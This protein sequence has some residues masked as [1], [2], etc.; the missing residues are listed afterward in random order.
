VNLTCA[1]DGKKT[2]GL[3]ITGLLSLVTLGIYNFIWLYHI[4]DRLKNAGA[5][6][7]GANILL[8]EILGSFIIVGPFIALNKLI[9]ALN[10]VNARYNDSH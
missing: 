8:W 6:I 1:G 10:F 5:N 4:S 3:I 9:K 7:D 2:N